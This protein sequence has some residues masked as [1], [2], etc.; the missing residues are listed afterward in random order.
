[1]P[2]TIGIALAGWVMGSL[3]NYL[4]DGLPLRRRI[5]RPFCQSCQEV[6]PAWNYFVWPRRCACCN[7][8]RK[9]R[10]WLVEGI[11]ITVS[12]SAWLA[13]PEKTGFILS[14]IFL[15]YLALVTV[16]DLEHH[17]ILHPVSLAG[18]LISIPVGTLAHGWLA[19]IFGGMAGFACMFAF[20]LFGKVFVR[21]IRRWNPAVDDE[22]LGFGDV[23][24]GAI[25]GF[26]LGWP[27]IL[28]GLLIAILIAGGVALMY[29]VVSL[30]RQDYRP[31]AVFP[32]GPTLVAAIVYLMYF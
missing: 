18:V 10:T 11:F 23:S 29:V 32:F 5:V 3:V 17:L 19:T 25:T 14:W 21:V 4:A 2:A 27:G 16:I 6:Q 13:P 8:R 7:S 20:Y 31:A 9:L 1:M 22:A 12:T 30:L 28:A 15:A 24:L 26:A